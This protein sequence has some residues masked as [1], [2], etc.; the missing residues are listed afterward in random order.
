MSYL[1]QVNCD[2]LKFEDPVVHELSGLA[3]HYYT[4]ALKYSGQDLI[5]PTQWFPSD[6][7]TSTYDRKELKVPLTKELFEFIQQIEEIAILKGLQLPSEYK[8]LTV[9]ASNADLFKRTAERP[10]LYLKTVP[11]LVCYDKNCKQIAEEELKMGN[12]RAAIHLKG[13]Y[14]GP[15]NNEK[16]VSLQLRIIQ[17]QNQPIIP[18]CVFMGLPCSPSKCFAVSNSAVEKVKQVEKESPVEVAPAA[19]SKT[20]NAKKARKPKLQRQNAMSEAQ[21]QEEQH[22][23]ETMS[24][25]FFEDVLKNN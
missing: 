25:E 11:N 22:A 9:N 16:L 8:P 6:G 24:A 4:Q 15:H 10:S 20:G 3:R 19:A 18:Q 23:M 17:V 12:Y 7:F 2:E 5:V 21:V 13:L 1:E 14:I